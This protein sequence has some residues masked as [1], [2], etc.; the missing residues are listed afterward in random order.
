MTQFLSQSNI[1]VF[2]GYATDGSAFGDTWTL[3][4]ATWTQQSPPNSPP[5]R[6]GM[7]STYD[8]ARQ[9]TLFFGGWDGTTVFGDLWAWNGSTWSQKS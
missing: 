3:S 9:E 4:G 2:G 1:V 6:W 5:P 7:P 8:R